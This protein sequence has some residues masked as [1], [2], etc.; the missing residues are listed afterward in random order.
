MA[1]G[2]PRSIQVPPNW[3]EMEAKYKQD[4]EA[5][6]E[7]A[8]MATIEKE[9]AEEKL[10]NC[11]R[12]LKELRDKLAEASLQIDMM[13]KDQQS[14]PS[15]GAGANES[16][17]T[18]LQLQK[19][20]EQ[21]EIL[22]QA[23]IKL[24]DMSAKDKKALEDLQIE[25]E[26]LELKLL[27]LEEK[28]QKYMEQIKIYE[29]QIDVSQ[30][31][32]EM[33]EKLTQQKTEL[34]DKLK[35]MIDDFDAMEKLR[36]LNEQLLESARENEIELTGEIDKLRVQCSELT[37]RRRDMEDYLS[38]Q[39]KTFA[40][41]KDENR[42]LKEELVRL[43]DHFKEGESIEQQKHQIEN[44]AYKLTFSES[45]MAEKEAE[46]SRY[47]RN[48][49]EM[50]EQMNNLSLI[51]KEQSA[52]LDELKLQYDAKVSE[53]SELQRALKKKLEEVSELEIRRDMAEKKLQSIQ[54]D[55]EA[56]IANLT[57]Q[58]ETMKGKEIQ[59]EEEL[60]RLLE[61]NDTIERER[62]E[63]RDQLNRSARSLERTMQTSNISMVTAQDTSLAS[64]GISLQSSASLQASPVQAH[65]QSF[66]AQTS[67]IASPIT[68]TTTAT[69]TTMGNLREVGG[70]G[71]KGPTSFGGAGSAAGGGGPATASAVAAPIA[72][73]LGPSSHRRLFASPA[74]SDA[75]DSVLLRRIKDLSVAF[76]LVARKNYDLELELAYNKLKPGCLPAYMTTGSKLADVYDIDR[77]KVLRAEVN[78]LKREIRASMINQQICT[79]SRQIHAQARDG[80]FNL[81]KLAMKCHTLELE[82]G[83][84]M[85]TSN[86][87]L[88]HSGRPMLQSTPVK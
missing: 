11:E 76:D 78:K 20:E 13:K 41:L 77:A 18:V 22:K 40:K 88:S 32:Q 3:A 49:S 58:I 44:V 51:T 66:G 12:E 52:R 31:A 6:T 7:S 57:R 84:L 37:T 43:K 69:T 85:S 60:K 46:I 48:L 68:T 36:D 19:V 87:V 50:E 39:E 64:L 47:K 86:L 17:V 63:L 29:E 8:E 73:P 25:H 42:N 54:K 74:T 75:D 33:V 81:S 70:G 9:I 24:R 53:N 61:D 67:F 26:E 62:R 79:R 34:E 21:N 10:D 35:E 15:V 5:L 2:I 30:S 71:G 1:S 55:K 80:H 65:Q 4:I 28:E 14:E 59:H 45:K 23:L 27:D 38:D 72:S 82:A 56:K 16:T 83:S